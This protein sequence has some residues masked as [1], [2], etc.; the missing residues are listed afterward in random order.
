MFTYLLRSHI[1][2]NDQCMISLI[3]LQRQLLLRLDPLL[4]QFFYLSRKHGRRINRG[5][6]TIGF[7]GDDYVAIILEKIVSI[8][9]DNACLI[10]LRHICE[11][12]IHHTDEH[13]I[14]V[15]VSCVF[16]DRDN[17]RTLFG[18]ID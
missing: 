5:V 17:I 18:H 13:A 2:S 12:Y 11:D 10:G 15:R 7:N 16:N 1:R 14:F 4:L 3:W 8:E 9:S 6:D